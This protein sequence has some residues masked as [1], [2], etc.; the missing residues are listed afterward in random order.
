VSECLAQRLHLTKVGANRQER[1]V[2][3]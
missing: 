3:L 2:M 1:V